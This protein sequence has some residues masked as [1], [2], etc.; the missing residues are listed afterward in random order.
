LGLNDQRRGTTREQ[1][2]H[3]EERGRRT[4]RA[5]DRSQAQRRL[6]NSDTAARA[7]LRVREGVDP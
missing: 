3:A 5:A 1:R 7:L 6:N 2:Y 4:R